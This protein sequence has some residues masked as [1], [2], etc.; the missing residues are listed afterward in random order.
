MRQE[1]EWDFVQK[2]V[3]ALLAR[4]WRVFC[5]SGRGAVMVHSDATRPG[6]VGLARLAYAPLAEERPRASARWDIEPLEK[7]DPEVDAVIV[8]LRRDGSERIVTF[9]LPGL[10]PQAAAALVMRTKRHWDVELRWIR[11]RGMD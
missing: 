2:Y 8:F 6:Y 1:D 5:E 7:Y 3:V 9:A 11:P 10:T 4:A